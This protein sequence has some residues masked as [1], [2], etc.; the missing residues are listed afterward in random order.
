MLAKYDGRAGPSVFLSQHLFSYMISQVLTRHV[1]QTFIDHGGQ[2]YQHALSRHT[3]LDV[4][5]TTIFAGV[6]LKPSTLS[7][8]TYCLIPR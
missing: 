6:S 5:E 4:T 1:E 3:V 7:Q 2:A 8:G